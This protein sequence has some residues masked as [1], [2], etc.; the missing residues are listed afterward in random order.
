[1]NVISDP[2][3]VSLFNAGQNEDKIVA[4]NLLVHDTLL[5]VSYYHEGMQVYS[6]KDPAD[7][8]KVA[9][10]QTYNQ[11][12]QIDSTSPVTKD[13]GGFRGVWGVY[14]YLPS[15]L[16]LAS[17]REKGLFVFKLDFENYVIPE[18]KT[19]FPNPFVNEFVLSY[20]SGAIIKIDLFDVNG[21]LVQTDLPHIP[22]K[23]MTLIR[24]IE[25]LSSGIY[26]VKI[27]A[28]QESFILKLT[29]I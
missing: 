21:K 24:T 1:M 2:T 4:H 27:Q 20:R 17:D 11:T 23:E 9:Y 3:V 14:P 19:V 25:N 7:P 10:Y 18:F 8:V 26:L 12:I 22:Y 29:K 16:I 15:G 6:I 13:Y 28:K 5:Y